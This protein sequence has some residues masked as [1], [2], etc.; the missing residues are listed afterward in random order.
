MLPVIADS[1]KHK[2]NN[3]D[4]AQKFAEWAHTAPFELVLL[5]YADCHDDPNIDDSFIRTLGQLD[6][7]YLGVF[8]VTAMIWFIRGFMKDAGR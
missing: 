2:N 6:R 5:A 1:V 4:A 8:C 3:A 7:F